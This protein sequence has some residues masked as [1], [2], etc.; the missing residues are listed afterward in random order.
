MKNIMSTD[1]GWR[2]T[3]KMLAKQDSG[4]GKAGRARQKGEEKTTDTV[5][6]RS[7]V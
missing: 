5:E 6:R 1:D 4:G 7:L 2:G 3:P